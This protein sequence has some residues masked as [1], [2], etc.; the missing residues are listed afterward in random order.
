[1]SRNM[2]DESV[3]GQCSKISLLQGRRL[4]A[5]YA[6]PDRRLWCSQRKKTTLGYNRGHD[7]DG[8]QQAG[9]PDGASLGQL[10]RREA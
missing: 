9:C 1:M 4:R 2:I 5:G 8:F 7:M 6:L 10:R 3:A